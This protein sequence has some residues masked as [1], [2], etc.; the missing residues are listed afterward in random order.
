MQRRAYLTTV[1]VAL[2]VAG[3]SG[4]ESTESTDTQDGS[5]TDSDAG[6]GETATMRQDLTDPAP[7]VRTV[8][9]VEEWANAGDVRR[10]ATSSVESGSDAEIGYRYRAFARKKRLDLT[11]DV[12]LYD[13]DER[14]ANETSEVERTAFRSGYGTWEGATAVSTSDLD[15]GEY[16]AEVTVRDELSGQESSATTSVEV[17]D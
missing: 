16:R 12:A 11:I 8:T 4:A 14:V 15:P 5:N 17:T 3:C 1:A 13:G 2:G 7:D 6:A 10:N 9:L